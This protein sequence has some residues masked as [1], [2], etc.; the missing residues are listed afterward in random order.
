MEH[1]SFDIFELLR[2]MA[3]N[4]KMI[5]AIVLIVAIAA[6]IYSL[7]TPQIFSSRASFFSVGDQ[8][9]SLPINIPG[10]SGVAA[11]LL[12]SEGSPNAENLTTVMRS[13]TFAEDL[14]REFKLIDYFKLTHPD[15][16]RNLDDAIEKLRGKMFS[17]GYDDASGLIS[18]KISSKDKQLSLDMVNYL[19]QK[20]DKYNREQKVTQG[21]L[22]RQFLE[23]RVKEIEASLDS[24][25]ERS[26]EMGES[27]KV[28]HL[29]AQGEAIIKSYTELIAEGMKADLDLEMAKAN[30]G[31]NSP[32]MQAAILRRNS[33]QKQ[34]RDLEENKNTP[35]YLLD[36]GKLPQITA[37]H[38]RLEMNM[39]INRT[40]YEYIYPQYEAARLVELKDMPTIDILDAPRLAG[41]RD[42]P[43]RAIICI[44][45]TLVAFVFAVAVALLIE[46]FK[47]NKH[48]VSAITN[49]L[50]K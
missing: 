28:V 21:K 38:L 37:D 50:K 16:L 9:S 24:L 11:S 43:K 42:Y 14:I 19:L 23:G 3:E 5:I 20:L 34:I 36:M 35:E 27:T 41:R 29:E 12:G 17:T 31:E 49:S 15:S 6:V 40:L 4:R 26:R 2:I 13:R 8:S 33:I 32:V 1:K 47:R 48:R 10:L 7:L 46:L 44:I 18:I 25:I 22:N 45:S 30:Y 39:Q